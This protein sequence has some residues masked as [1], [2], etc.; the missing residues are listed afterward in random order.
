MN[1]YPGNIAAAAGLTAISIQR[2]TVAI[3]TYSSGMCVGGLLAFEN[4]VQQDSGTAFLH[5]ALIVDLSNQKPPGNI[6]IFDRD[7]TQTANGGATISDHV[8]FAWGTAHPYLV[9]QIPVS[10]SDY[11]TV[12]SVA[13]A[14][15]PNLG[16]L[17]G[18][19]S[20]TTL[21]AAFVLNAALGTGFSGSQ[22]LIAKIKTVPQI[23]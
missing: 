22:Q 18:V 19:N 10:A 23:N 9:T 7:V 11:I 21:Y 20:G 6:L 5:H 12:A 3:N 4:A 17:F 14:S 16:R 13:V 2:P 8:T 1:P 15:Y